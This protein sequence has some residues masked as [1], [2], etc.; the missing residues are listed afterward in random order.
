MKTISLESRILVYEDRVELPADI[1]KLLVE[2]EHA[3]TRAY[4]PYSHF[5]VGAAILMNNGQVVTGCN[6]ENAVYPCGLCAERTAAFAASAKF[7]EVP[8]SRIAIT[9]INPVEPLKVP[10]SPCGSC[11]QVLYEY[12]QKFG[13]P[14]EV[15][16]AGQ[17]GPIYHLRCVADLLPYTFHAGFLP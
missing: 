17:E 14:I 11:R 5:Q 1:L 6:Q 12:E 4:A 8:F 10:V 16:L 13:Q 9:A 2:A 15:I 7:P 3:A